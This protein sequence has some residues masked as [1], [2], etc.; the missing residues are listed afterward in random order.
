MFKEGVQQYIIMTS[1]EEFC[2]GMENPEEHEG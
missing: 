2:P 1:G